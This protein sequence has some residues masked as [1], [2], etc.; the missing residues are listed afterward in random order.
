MEAN[1]QIEQP[2]FRHPITTIII[3]AGMLLTL[4]INALTLLNCWSMIGYAQWDFGALTHDQDIQEV[5]QTVFYSKTTR[6]HTF[7]PIFYK[8][9]C[10]FKL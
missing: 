1:N 8:K 10:V 2:K 3:V 4:I 7:S 6:N 9:K 5:R